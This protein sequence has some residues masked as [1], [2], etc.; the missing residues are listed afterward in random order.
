MLHAREQKCALCSEQHRVR[1]DTLR[2]CCAEDV[3]I[4]RDCDELA[5]WVDADATAQCQLDS[6]VR[7][8]ALI[9]LEVNESSDIIQGGTP[10]RAAFGV[11]LLQCGQLLL[12]L[13]ARFSIGHLW[14]QGSTARVCERVRGY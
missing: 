9:R 6:G 5:G 14:A 13:D 2:V 11:E 8:R 10:D 12:D 1:R 7:C 4:R 3:A